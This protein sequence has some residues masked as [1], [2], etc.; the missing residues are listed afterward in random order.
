MSKF[1]A[2]T[3]DAVKEA[4]LAAVKNVRSGPDLGLRVDEAWHISA[5]YVG[6]FVARE[7]FKRGLIDRS[8]GREVIKEIGG[9]ESDADRWRQP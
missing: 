6:E 9:A 7:L 4:I 2:K 8:T 3:Q 1:D 5:S